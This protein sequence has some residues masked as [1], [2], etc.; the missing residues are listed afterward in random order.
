MRKYCGLEHKKRPRYRFGSEAQLNGVGA[1]NRERLAAA[2]LTHSTAPDFIYI[3]LVMVTANGLC[4]SCVASNGIDHGS[5]Q[6]PRL[7][8]F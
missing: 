8:F 1:T 3:P 6:R 7:K 2:Q 5:G 4:T